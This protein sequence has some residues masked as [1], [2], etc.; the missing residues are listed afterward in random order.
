MKKTFLLLQGIFLIVSAFS[1]TRNVQEFSETENVPLYHTWNSLKEME[2]GMPVSPVPLETLPQDF[3]PW[4]GIASHHALAHEYI[5]AW[6]SRLAKIRKPRRFFILS[7]SH[8]GIS[9][10][11]Y[12]LT[13]GSWESGFGFVESDR[14]KVREL[15]G[16]LEVDLDPDVFQIEHGVSTLMPYIKKYFPESKVVAIACK[17]EAPVNIPISSRLSDI[18]ENEFNEAGKME[19][20]LLIS[21]DFSHHGNP[22]VTY[23]NDNNSELYLRNSNDIFWGMAVCDNYPGIYIL[24]QLG[25]KKLESCILYHTNSWEISNQGENDITSY[26]FVYFADRFY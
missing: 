4:A 5:D 20:F 26:F 22:E 2:Y 16:M 19:N 11:T 1:C 8:Y 21:A 7:P 23:K 6:F 10:E 18:L 12:S 9:L 25:K 13:I 17:G 14:D 24:D 15:A 3:F